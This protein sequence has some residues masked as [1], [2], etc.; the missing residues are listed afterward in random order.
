MT[1]SG[2]PV[3][4]G[5]HG[6][7]PEENI[8]LFNG[9]LTLRYLDI[10]LPGPNGLNLNIWRVYNSKLYNDIGIG[11]G[12][13]QLQQEPYSW[14]GMGW[15]MHM[16]R[17]HNA[18]TLPTIE[19]PDGKW[20]TA[21]FDSYGSGLYVTKDFNRYDKNEHKF[22]FPDGT[23]WTFGVVQ[24]ITYAD[25]TESVRLLTKIEN[26]SGQS[27][28]VTYKQGLPILDV[29]TDAFGRTVTF[30]NNGA[31]SPKLTEIIVKN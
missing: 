28:N 15:I 27:I 8:D 14:V 17:V 12:Q 5:M 3:E 19:F 11:G 25:H 9:N 24:N 21:Y 6:A 4:H 1:A 2:S 13:P 20:D 7:V 18:D 16:G 30:I 23:V 29:I 31:P 22:Y 26:P 10:S